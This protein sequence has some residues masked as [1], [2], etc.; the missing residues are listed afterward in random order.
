MT[1]RHSNYRHI[2]LGFVVTKTKLEW[3][4]FGLMENLLGSHLTESWIS[5]LMENTSKEEAI[6][7]FIT[8]RVIDI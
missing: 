5:A 1:K 6:S 3:E 8:E 2:Y 7:I 4:T